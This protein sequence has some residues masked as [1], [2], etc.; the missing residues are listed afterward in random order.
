VGA[1]DLFKID[2]EA[3]DILIETL[4]KAI[5][6]GPRHRF[7]PETTKQEATVTRVKKWLETDWAAEMRLNIESNTKWGSDA[8]L[9]VSSSSSFL[10]SPSL[11]FFLQK[12]TA[13]LRS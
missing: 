1:S 10:P 8:R 7:I 3:D 11:S 5:N 9:K 13:L 4:R 2:P 6:V 12:S